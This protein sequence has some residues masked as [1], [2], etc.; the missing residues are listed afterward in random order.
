MWPATITLLGP[1][2]SAK[3]RVIVDGGDYPGLEQ[4]VNRGRLV[5]PWTEA[6]A[7]LADERRLVACQEHPIR[8]ASDTEYDAVDDILM[9]CA[10]PNDLHLGWTGL[11]RG[12]LV[13]HDRA[14]T[15][16]YLG[17]SEHWLDGQPGAFT[18]RRGTSFA[19]Y[20]TARWVAQRIGGRDARRTLEAVGKDEADLRKKAVEGYDL[21]G[22]TNW[23]GSPTHVPAEWCTERLAKREPIFALIRSWCG[24]T[25]VAKWDE[26]AALKAEVERL[27][28]L[29]EEA[30]TTL[31]WH[32]HPHLSRRLDRKLRGLPEDEPK[33]S[34]RQRTDP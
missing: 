2:K 28:G 24:E 9:A 14:T 30:I 13:V 25:E 22:S 10:L 33:H 5:V 27:R 8:E 20:V 11:E 31:K 21:E 1:P 26:A 7:W 34:K 32:N 4:W 3:F 17:L 18:D 29:V 23:D 12:L 16:E 6:E 19:P 15:A